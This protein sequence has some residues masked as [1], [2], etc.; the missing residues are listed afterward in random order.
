VAL[1][2]DPKFEFYEPVPIKKT[3]MPRVLPDRTDRNRDDAVVYLHDV[4]LGPGLEGVPRGTVKNLRIV[5]YNFGMPR[6]AGPD[7]IGRGGPW[8]AMRI[9]GTVPV[10]EDGSVAFKVPASTPISVQPLDEDG[11]ALQLMRS[12]Y[13]AMPGE[14]ASCVGCHEQPKDTPLVRYET[15]AV[16]MPVEIE[17]WYGPARGLD[18]E[19]EVQ[20]V[21]DRYCVGCHDGAPDKLDLRAERFAQN[22]EGSPLSNLGAKRLDP[23][24]VPKFAPYESDHPYIGNI[25]M[26]YTP[27]YEALIPFIRRVNVEDHVGLHVPCEY[28]AGTSELV[29][30]LEKGHFGV[31]LDEEA[32]DRLIT[33]I[34]LNGPCHG[35]WGD[36]A[37]IPGDGA[38]RRRELALKY[39]GPKDDPEA[40]YETP[41]YEGEP[42]VPVQQA[43]RPVPITLAGWPLKME[44]AVARQRTSGPW[45]TTVD[46]GSGIGLDLVRIPAGKFVI[47]DA[48]G[49]RD[50]RPQA[51]VAIA[52]DFWM[53]TCE[54]S[55]EQFRRFKADHFSG[56]FMKRS[57]DVN[58]PGIAMDQ[59]R[60]PAVRVSWEEAVAFCRWLSE[61]TGRRFRLPTEAEWE[62]ASRA[63]GDSP[64]GYGPLDADFSKYA[65]LADAAVARFNSV[66][67]GV[68]VL[69]DIPADGR[70]DDGAIA[71]AAVGS[72][73]P[74][75]WGLF[76]MHGNAAEWTLSAYAPYPYRSGDGRDELKTGGRKV[77]RGG[78]F[79]DRPKRCRS[80]FRLSYPAWQKVHNVGFRVVCETDA[81]DLAT[82]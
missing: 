70:Y 66:T 1:A 77:V 44:D 78:S 56:Y 74:N 30:M 14:K 43:A 19:R 2:F 5:A 54:V 18:F 49:E 20:P 38:R 68:I 82:R 7:K 60:Q 17:P 80:S 45:E 52:S 67:A 40:V 12:W 41:R 11:K 51:V 50:E 42:I 69:Q 16:K 34:D 64:L 32:R 59:P 73:E 55:N 63:G 9:L 72:Y 33:W 26:R 61:E 76:D 58:G 27:A 35:T 8:E 15:A 25:K 75:A 53:S 23:E 10:P 22:Y 81:A 79:Y 48:D 24:L 13:T 71:T 37:E 4:Y 36:V 65:N 39:G 31:E 28:H 29:Q 46:L 57:L 62:Y 3:A 21:L 47:G 6:M